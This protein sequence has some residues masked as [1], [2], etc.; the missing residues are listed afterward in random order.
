MY[1]QIFWAVAS[2][3]VYFYKSPRLLCL[4]FDLKTVTGIHFLNSNSCL[5]L[6]LV[7][8]GEKFDKVSVHFGCVL[9]TGSAIQSF[10]C[11]S[12][13]GLVS[14]IGCPFIFLNRVCFWPPR[15]FQSPY[16]YPWSLPHSITNFQSKISVIYMTHFHFRI[17]NVWLGTIIIMLILNIKEQVCKFNCL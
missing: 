16:S 3:R 2:F 4:V 10:F 7:F 12:F 17:D 6:T 1:F 13:Y 11:N 5:M 9:L 8:P 15:I 14:F